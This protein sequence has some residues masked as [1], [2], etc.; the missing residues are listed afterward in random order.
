MRHLLIIGLI[1]SLG[2]SICNA[3]EKGD[4]D[5]RA[6]AQNPVIPVSVGGW[7]LIADTALGGRGRIH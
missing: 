6:K 7:K 1:P 3:K 5:L 4:D 2:A